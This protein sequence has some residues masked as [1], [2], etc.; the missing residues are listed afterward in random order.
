VQHVRVLNSTRGSCLATDAELASSFFAK[1]A[2]LMLRKNLAEGGGL[3]IM[4]G[5]PIHMFFMRFALDV[6]H[7]NQQGVV[8]RILH[9]IKPWRLGPF[10]RKCRMAIELPAG[11]AA[12]TGTVV[13]DVIVLE[14][15]EP[16]GP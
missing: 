16:Q 10:V 5:E 15:I 4:S 3:V 2:G 13:G 12:R 8:L 1:F 14:D 9:G 11:T 6:I 7:T